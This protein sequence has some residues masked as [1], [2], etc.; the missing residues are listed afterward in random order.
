MIFY[1]REELVTARQLLL[2]NPQGRNLLTFIHFGGRSKEDLASGTQEE[3]NSHDLLTSQKNVGLQISECANLSSLQVC[4]SAVCKSGVCK[5][6]VCSLRLS[7]TALPSTIQ[8]TYCSLISYPDLT[9]FYTRLIVLQLDW[10]HAS[11]GQQ[12]NEQSAFK[13]TPIWVQSICSCW[14]RMN[15]NYWFKRCTW[16]RELLFGKLVTSQLKYQTWRATWQVMRSVIEFREFSKS[17]KR[18]F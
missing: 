17:K 15:L 9:L 18:W 10:K 2:C 6:A 13:I 1:C 11:C 12:T 8:L 16:R 7:H 14:V 5:S 4:R 3:R